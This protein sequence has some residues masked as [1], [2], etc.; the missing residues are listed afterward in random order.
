MPPVRYL[1]ADGAGA[2]IVSTW[3]DRGRPAATCRVPRPREHDGHLHSPAPPVRLDHGPDFYAPALLR[4]P[5]EADGCCGAGRGKPATTPGC[6]RRAG[7]GVLTLPREIHS[8]RRRH[9]SRQQP[10]RELLALRGE[11]LLRRT[12]RDPGPE[13]VDTRRSRPHLRPHR[14]C[15]CPTGPARR[16]AAGHLRRT[17]P[18]T[19]TSA[20]TPPPA[21]WSSTATTPHWTPG[22]AAGTYRMPCPA[23]RSPA[24][25]ELRVVVDHSIAEIFLRHRPGPHPALLPARGRAPG[26]A[27]PHRT[28]YAPRL[29]GRRVGTAPARDQ[30][31]EHQ[32]RRAGAGVAVE[33]TPT[34]RSPTSAMCPTPS[35]KY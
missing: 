20:S 4:A 29:L 13:P 14:P 7:P 24:P 26:A 17:A 5:G 23:A 30:G 16:S 6:A 19:S 33:P 3:D 35:P 31:A 12:G 1:A 10:A 18:S 8:R 2:L 25:V 9:A 22:R 28:G 15:W 11:Q 27:G 21:S 34:G 32:R